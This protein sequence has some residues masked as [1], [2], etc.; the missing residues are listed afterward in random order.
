MNNHRILIFVTMTLFLL[1]GSCKD[2]PTSEKDNF[3]GITDIDGNEYNIIKIGNQWWMAENLKVTHYNNGDSIPSVT[4]N[5]N[6]GNKMNGSTCSYENQ[7][8]AP[9]V[10]GRL[11]NWYAIKD[12]RN[13]APKGWH[14]PTDSEWKEMEVYIGMKQSETNQNGYRGIGIGGKLKSDN[15]QWIRPNIGANDSVGFSA[16]GSGLRMSDGSFTALLYSALFWTSSASRVDSSKAIFRELDNNTSAIN[17]AEE[18][19]QYG[20][21]VRCVKD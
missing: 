17:R 9:N 11:Y 18:Y 12:S 2:N 21:S 19:K 15:I 1:I 16:I 13:I 7:G 10:Y 4:N 8:Y 3:E 14:I 20:F 6:W 5:E